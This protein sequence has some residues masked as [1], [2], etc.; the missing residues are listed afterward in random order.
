MVFDI[1]MILALLTTRPKFVNGPFN[2]TSVLI[3]TGVWF[4]IGI[5]FGSMMLGYTAQVLDEDGIISGKGNEIILEPEKWIGKKFPLMN[6]IEISELPKD[7]V[8]L[9]LLYHHN[10]SACRESVEQYSKLAIEF[11]QKE[12][13]PKIAIIEVPPFETNRDTKN[14]D[15]PAVHGKL[16]GKRKWKIKT[17]VLILVDNSNYSVDWSFDGRQ[18]F[19]ER[20]RCR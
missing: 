5:P 6:H 4:M 16:D 15:C 17:P 10:C 2:I 11:A 9:V 14:K 1:T 20:L 7:D 13:R 12:K 3:I 19:A 18:P 8:W